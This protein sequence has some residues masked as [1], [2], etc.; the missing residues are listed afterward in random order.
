MKISGAEIWDSLKMTN[1]N[2]TMKNNSINWI[3]SNRVMF[4]NYKKTHTQQKSDTKMYWWKRLEKI[5][6][7]KYKK[8]E[9]FVVKCTIFDLLKWNAK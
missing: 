8:K 3:L 1:L 7:N 2:S 4:G 9:K 5:M 6:F